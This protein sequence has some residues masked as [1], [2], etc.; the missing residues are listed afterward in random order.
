LKRLQQ[1]LSAPLVDGIVTNLTQAIEQ[2][3]PMAPQTEEPHP[4]SL[5]P[6]NEQERLAELHRSGL[7]EEGTEKPF[8]ES[9][10]RDLAKAFNMP[11]AAMVLVDEHTLLWKS[12]T[13]LP[14]A[15]QE[16]ELS[17]EESISSHVVGRNDLLMVPDL[18]RDP[19]FAKDPLLQHGIRFYVGAPLRTQAGFVL[20]ALCLMDHQPRRLTERELELLRLVSNH[21]M[22]QVQFRIDSRHS[23]QERADSAEHAQR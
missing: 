5:I 22:E 21:L 4:V 15:L 7:L 14:A 1:R 19:R 20:G 3:A 9:I 17:R 6:A 23:H 8:F 2:I 12:Q 13:G 16:Q 10:T 11:V 18:A